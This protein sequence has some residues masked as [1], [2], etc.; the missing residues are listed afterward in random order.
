MQHQAV[1]ASPGSAVGPDRPGQP[2]QGGPFFVR[3]VEFESKAIPK[4]CFE[5]GPLNDKLFLRNLF[6]HHR[7]VARPLAQSM[8]AVRLVP[9]QT[10]P[11]SKVGGR[12][13]YGPMIGHDDVRLEYPILLR[14]VQILNAVGDLPSSTAT[15]APRLRPAASDTPLPRRYRPVRPESVPGASAPQIQR[16]P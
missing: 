9:S 11:Q 4:E 2:H 8:H 6:V 7:S 14:A 10:E 1:G 3:R 15:R 13:R 5:L 16:R 12:S